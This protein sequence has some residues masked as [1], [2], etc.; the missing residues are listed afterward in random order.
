MAI[1]D[2]IQKFAGVTEEY[3]FYNGEVTLRYDVAAHVYL[4]QLD[5]G[6]LEPVNGVTSVVHIIDKSSALVP[7]GAKMMYQKLLMTVP[8]TESKAIEEGLEKTNRYIAPMTFD[9]FDKLIF[10]AK[11]AHTEK[12]EEAGNVGHIAHAWIEDYIKLSLA[13]KEA[14][15][16]EYALLDQRLSDHLKNMPVLHNEETGEIDDRPKNCCIAALDWMQRHSVK[17][18]STEKKIYSRKHKYAGT[19]DGLCYCS[20]CDNPLCC[21]E[22]FTNRLTV[23]DW[24]TSNYLYLEYVL[25]TAAYLSAVNEEIIDTWKHGDPEIEL[26]SQR[27]VIRLGKE[28]AAFEAWHLGDETTQ[29]DFDGFLEC[30]ALVRRVAKI[31]ARIAARKADVRA[32]LKAERD[33][34]RRL[35]DEADRAE[36]LRVKEESHQA[37]VEAHKLA[38][39]ASKTYKGSRKS[40]CTSGEGGKPCVSCT[41][42]YAKKQEEIEAKKSKPKKQSNIGAFPHKEKICATSVTELIKEPTPPIGIPFTYPNNLLAALVRYEKPQLLLPEPSLSPEL[43]TQ[44]LI[45]ELFNLPVVGS[46]NVD[47][48]TFT[49]KD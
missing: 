17:W 37:R 16:A 5:N 14:S 8:V 46:L 25:Q 26:A 49:E 47:T 20:S 24:K 40:S 15:N 22:A 4:L 1:S 21:P 10:E 19:M 13:K 28:D 29:D 41:F 38:C 48:N 39:P 23:A 12:L 6:E 43:G 9:E 42:K 36:R 18:V 30:L 7:W 44:S 33:E 3:K 32:A 2:F 34:A 27:W 31:D 35:K 11:N 45:A